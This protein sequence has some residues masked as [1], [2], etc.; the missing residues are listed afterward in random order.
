[1][2]DAYAALGLILIVAV[3]ACL[4]PPVARSAPP[5]LPAESCATWM[6][7]AIPG[8]GTKSRERIAGEIRAGTIPAAADGWFIPPER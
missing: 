8:V 7:D 2:R 6:A 3:Y 5:P 4:R 1:M